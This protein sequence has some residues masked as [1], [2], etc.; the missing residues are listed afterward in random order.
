M[1]SWCDYKISSIN[2]AVTSFAKCRALFGSFLFLSFDF[3]GG[4]G[5]SFF[6]KLIQKYIVTVIAVNLLLLSV[7]DFKEN[8]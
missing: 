6:K 5:W 3:W 8:V 2:Y 7:L 4:I 1:S